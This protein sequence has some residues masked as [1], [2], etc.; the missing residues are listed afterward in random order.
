MTVQQFIDI[1]RLYPLDAEIHLFGR[2]GETGLDVYNRNALRKPLGD[3]PTPSEPDFT[4]GDA[5]EMAELNDDEPVLFV[6]AVPVDE[7]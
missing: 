3:V 4:V 2:C 1:L 7:K 5:R 6:D